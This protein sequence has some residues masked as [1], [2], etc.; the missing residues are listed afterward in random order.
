MQERP[1]IAYQN[2]L[3]RPQIWS[4]LKTAGQYIVLI[5][6]WFYIMQVYL[7]FGKWIGLSVGIMWV[8]GAL[9]AWWLPE[10]REFLIKDTKYWIFYYLLF[11]GGYRFAM[12]HLVEITP[13]QVQASLDVPI[14]AA[15]GLTAI[16]FL[17]T[18]LFIVLFTVP[19]GFA[20]W[21]VQHMKRFRIGMSKRE[22]FRELRA[23]H[24]ERHRT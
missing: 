15:S 17:E 22:K 5:A 1:H 19:M 6:L 9:S 18:G 4:G 13:E 24:D 7:S 3:S 8:L 23:S 14:P 10:E 12:Q 11:L 2:D 21:M 20:V 16:G